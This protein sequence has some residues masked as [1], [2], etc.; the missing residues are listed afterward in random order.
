MD[1]LFGFILLQ[2]KLVSTCLEKE[3]QHHYR[4]LR[5][6]LETLTEVNTIIIV[7]FYS[8]VEYIDISS[9]TTTL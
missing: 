1:N 8:N 5:I 3:I 6:Y 7:G 2:I 9:S 4:F